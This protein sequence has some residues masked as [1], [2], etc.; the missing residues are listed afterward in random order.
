MSLEYLQV[1]E[2][3]VDTTTP[4]KQL[5]DAAMTPFGEYVYVNHRSKSYNLTFFL[6]NFLT[7]MFFH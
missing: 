4:L 7:L 2:D 3:F 1:A 6:Q 5:A